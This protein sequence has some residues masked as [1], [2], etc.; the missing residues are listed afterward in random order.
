MEYQLHS[1]QAGFLERRRRGQGQC[2]GTAIGSPVWFWE[3]EYTCYPDEAAAGVCL[4]YDSW[5]TYETGKREGHWTE[6]EFKN[7]VVE[8][9]CIDGKR[10]VEWIEHRDG[11][12]YRHRYIHGEFLRR[13]AFHVDAG[14]AGSHLSL[15][16]RSEPLMSDN[17]SQSCVVPPRSTGSEFGGTDAYP[18]D[19]GANSRARCGSPRSHRTC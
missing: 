19:A 13:P 15:I 10:R 9:P 7:S 4:P 18:P 1:A 5:G 14:P 17:R 12:V 3:H 11:K 8:R 6:R 16:R 2:R